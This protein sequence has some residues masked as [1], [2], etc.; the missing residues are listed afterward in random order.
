MTSERLL[1]V[2]FQLGGALGE[3]WQ[4]GSRVSRF[5]CMSLFLSWLSRCS[6]SL[7]ELIRGYCDVLILIIY[8]PWVLCYSKP[9][10]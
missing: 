1:E 3:V 5:K 8:Y 6:P 9:I 4:A 2:G 10:L 7:L